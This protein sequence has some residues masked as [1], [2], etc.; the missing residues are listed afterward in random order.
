MADLNIL[1]TGISPVWPEQAEI[2]SYKAAADLSA[3][4]LLYVDASG[5]VGKADGNGPSPKN[6]FRGIALQSAKAGQTLD[7]LVAGYIQGYDVSGLAYD[8]AVYVSDS[9]GALAD[10]AGTTSLLVG[11]VVP[12]ND[13]GKSKILRITGW[14]G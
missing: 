8:T 2:K 1:P 3:G 4:N 5:K 12:M 13:P 10:T 6:R 14:A 11:R 7:V 9:A